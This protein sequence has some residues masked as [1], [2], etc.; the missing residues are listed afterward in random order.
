MKISDAE[1]VTG[2]TGKAIRLYEEKGLISVERQENS[3]RDYNDETILRLKQ[4]K[5]F[6]DL[7]IGINEIILCFNGVVSKEE[8][9]SVLVV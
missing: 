2:L 3:Y 7:G 5:L 4:I 8:L 9:I 6:R 1:K